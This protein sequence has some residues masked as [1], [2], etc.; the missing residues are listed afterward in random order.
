MQRSDDKSNQ[1][2]SLEY[3]SPAIVQLSNDER[4]LVST[5]WGIHQIRAVNRICGDKFVIGCDV[6]DRVTD[7]SFSGFG[8]AISRA[9]IVL[10]LDVLEQKTWDE[11]VVLCEGAIRYFKGESQAPPLED[12]RFE[13]FLPVQR[14]PGRMQCVLLGWESV[15]EYA[16]EMAKG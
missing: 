5:A 12:E 3:Y 15:L 7:R 14:Y 9:S 11:V 2:P 6:D 1:G 4:Y 10:L 13:E 16:R 8:C